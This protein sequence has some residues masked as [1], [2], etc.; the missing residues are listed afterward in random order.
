MVCQLDEDDVDSTNNAFRLGVGHCHDDAFERH[1]S[2]FLP[3][4]DHGQG[5]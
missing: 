4:K 3:A 2:R 1:D 5:R